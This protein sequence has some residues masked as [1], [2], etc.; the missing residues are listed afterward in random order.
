VRRVVAVGVLLGLWLSPGPS[1]GA[2]ALAQPATSVPPPSLTASGAVLWDPA[3]EVALF[4]K[5]A[6]VARPMASTTKIMTVL[7]ALEAGA[8]DGELTVSAH[9]AEVGATPG[10]ATLGLSAGQ[11]IGVRSVL[12]GL[13]LRSGNDAAVAVAEH[14]AGSEQAFVDRMNARARELGL[15]QTQFRNASGLTDDP[16]HRSS[17]IDLARLA[18]VAMAHPDFAA[19]AGATSLDVPGLGT[20]EN[21]NELLGRYPGATGVK[22]GFTTLAG[23]CLVASAARDGRT[24]YAVVLDSDD[25]FAD[26]TLLLD[27]GFG[28]FRRPEPVPQ[29]GV[30][31]RYRWA[32]ADVG[33]VTAAPL[34]RTVGVDAVVTWRTRVEPAAARPVAAGARLGRA[35]LVVDGVVERTVD[36]LAEAGVPAPAAPRAPAARAGDAVA[37]AVRS[38]ARLAAFDRAA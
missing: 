11:R 32:G 38:F 23:L 37:D 10:G 26:T 29:G 9:A 34:A 19:W 17:P 31:T 14:V 27:H 2:R 24:L 8:A 28:A 13:V 3:D 35:E 15:A 22:T 5:E 6:D 4:G 18:A 1:P 33:L 20:L 25:S 16:E 7:L 30:A 21:R 36:L 12:A